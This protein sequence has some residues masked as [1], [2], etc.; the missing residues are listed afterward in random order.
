LKFAAPEVISNLEVEQHHKTKKDIWSVGVLTY[1]LLSGDCPFLGVSE[2]EIGNKILIAE[3]GFEGSDQ[4][5]VW[6]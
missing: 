5:N 4:Q 1:L 2:E 3:F 6:D